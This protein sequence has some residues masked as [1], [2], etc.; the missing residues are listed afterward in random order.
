MSVAFITTCVKKPDKVTIWGLVI[1]VRRNLN[2]IKLDGLIEPDHRSHPKLA[3]D[4]P[5]V[6]LGVYIPGLIDFMET[7]TLYHNDIDTSA[8]SN[9]DI[10]HTPGVC[11]A[12]TDPTP[13]FA[14]INPKPETHINY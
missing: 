7:E 4:L 2:R 13:F 3:F 14:P 5:G 6:I 10:T 12:S 11:D 9:S 1:S 8:A